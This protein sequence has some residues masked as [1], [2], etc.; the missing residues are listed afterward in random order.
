MNFPL[1]ALVANARL[2]LASIVSFASRTSSLDRSST[3]SQ[4]AADISDMFVIDATDGIRPLFSSVMDMT[5]A[6]I[7]SDFQLEIQMAAGSILP[8][9]RARFRVKKHRVVY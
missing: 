6:R 2:S 3:V 4:L 1:D 8:T 7:D 5:T 9:L